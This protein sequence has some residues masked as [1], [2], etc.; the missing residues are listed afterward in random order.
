M[1]AGL[2]ERNLESSPNS[3]LAELYFTADIRTDQMPPA[4]D[5]KLSEEYCCS[6]FISGDKIG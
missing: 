1:S 2:D 4:S 6:L 5:A 3:A